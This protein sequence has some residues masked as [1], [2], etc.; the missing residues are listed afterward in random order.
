ML[1]T[2]SSVLTLQFTPTYP[3]SRQ[4]I[5]GLLKK[6]GLQIEKLALCIVEFTCTYDSYAMLIYYKR[7]IRKLRQ[8]TPK[9]RVITIKNCAIIPE[10]QAS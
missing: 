9:I 2:R 10:L 7:F 4:N 6:I 1:N 3:L 5:F 8:F